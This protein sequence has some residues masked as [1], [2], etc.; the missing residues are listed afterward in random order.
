MRVGIGD[1][2]CSMA[3]Q[4]PSLVVIVCEKSVPDKDSE[5]GRRWKWLYSAF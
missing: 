4:P 1:S 5:L 3:G 2:A